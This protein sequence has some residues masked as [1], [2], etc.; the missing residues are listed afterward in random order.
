MGGKEEPEKE[1]GIRK[2]S[3]KLQLLNGNVNVLSNNF[4]KLRYPFHKERQR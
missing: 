4:K 2:I 1:R 3:E